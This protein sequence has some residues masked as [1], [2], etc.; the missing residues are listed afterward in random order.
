MKNSSCLIIAEAGV[1]HNGDIKKAFELVK[2]ASKCKADYIKFQMFDTNSLVTPNA[3]KAN[4]QVDENP[5]DSQYAMLKKL[6]RSE[7]VNYP[8]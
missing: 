6:E 2:M 7:K 5:V 4:Y 1:N 3:K 8:L